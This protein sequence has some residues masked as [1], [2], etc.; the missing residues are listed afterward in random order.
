MLLLTTPAQHAADNPAVELNPK[1]LKKWAAQLPVTNVIE[2]VQ[3]LHH[4]IQPFNELRLDNADRLKLLE[5]Y[6]Q[7]FEDILF[8]YDDLR[9]R[10]LPIPAAQRKTLAEDI[11]WLYLELATGYKIIV[12]NAQEQGRKPKRDSV[13]LLAMYRAM[14]LVIHAL[15]YTYRA[16]QSAPPLSYLEI[17]QIYLLAEEGKVLTTKVRSVKSETGGATIDKLYKQFLLLTVANPYKLNGG[18]I[19][20][21]FILLEHFLQHCELE[22]SVTC[23]KGQKTFFL[24]LMDDAPPKSCE[25]AADMVSSEFTRILDVSGVVG[26]IKSKMEHSPVNDNGLFGEEEHLLKILAKQLESQHGSLGVSAQANKKVKVALGYQAVCHFLKDE[27]RLRDALDSSAEV[28]GGIEVRNI[29]EETE[30]EFELLP[31]TLMAEDNNTSVLLAKQSSFPA[32][33]QIG[34]VFSLFEDKSSGKPIISLGTLRWKNNEDDDTLKLELEKLQGIPIVAG[35]S[36]ANTESQFDVLYFPKSPENP[37]YAS[38]LI[39]KQHYQRDSL[40]LTTINGKRFKVQQGEICSE[41]QILARIR[42]AV[43]RN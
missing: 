31:L 13:L 4:S 35:C 25:F 10:Q 38:L 2:T 20:E 39:E 26:A 37:Q 7:A 6:H 22:K 12:K 41:T 3:L 43:I 15:L 34:D 14:E 23:K 17:H 1:R 29:D 36:D 32:G 19:Y 40:M 42:F 18:E 28:H 33:L 8:F 27:A 5:I 24:D 11:M 21:F 9:I 30:A 16:Q